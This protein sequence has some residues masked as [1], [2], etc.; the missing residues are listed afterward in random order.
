MN[1]ENLLLL[2]GTHFDIF[3][4]NVDKIDKNLTAP[5]ELDYNFK[6]NTNKII[7]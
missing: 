2:L 3:V 4:K 6:T 1:L 5:D 7:I